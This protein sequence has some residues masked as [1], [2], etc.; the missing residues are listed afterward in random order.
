[1]VHFLSVPVLTRAGPHAMQSTRTR[2]NERT[3]A[4]ALSARDDVASG[5]AVPVR[6]RVGGHR[7]LSHRVAWR[8]GMG[9]WFPARGA[10]RAPPL[11]QRQ[12]HPRAGLYI[13]PSPN[14]TESSPPPFSLPLLFSACLSSPHLASSPRFLR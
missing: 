6:P 5:L 9:P 2:P 10:E 13:P 12:R 3:E 4:I 14:P 1:V 11:A 8:E 7:F